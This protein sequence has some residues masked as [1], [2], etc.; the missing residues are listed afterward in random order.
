MQQVA[1]ET[2]VAFERRL[3]RAQVPAPQ[4][5]DYHRWTR[6]YLDFCHKYGHPGQGRS[7]LLAL[8]PAVDNPSPGCGSCAPN[9]P[10]RWITLVR[11]SR[12]N[13]PAGPGHTLLPSWH[14]GSSIGASPEP[15]R[16]HTVDNNVIYGVH[17]VCLRRA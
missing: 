11:G 2:W 14:L 3:E 5:P 4:R 10:E 1:R 6:F 16:M 8:L 7:S 15:H 9:I 12:G 17:T 13:C